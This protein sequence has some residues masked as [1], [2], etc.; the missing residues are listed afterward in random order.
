[1]VQITKKS[2]VL[3]V[4]L[5]EREVGLWKYRVPGELRS[6]V[7][8]GSQVPIGRAC[9]NVKPEGYLFVPKKGFRSTLRPGRDVEPRAPARRAVTRGET[10]GGRKS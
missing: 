2:P 5:K 6:H 7:D 1:M 10:R 8:G 3:I 4:V 9:G